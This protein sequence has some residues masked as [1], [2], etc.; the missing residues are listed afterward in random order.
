M[1]QPA[2]LRVNTLKS[3]T[4]YHKKCKELLSSHDSL[5][6]HAIGQATGMLIKLCEILQRKEPFK[7]KKLESVGFLDRKQYKKRKLKL[8]ALW[9]TP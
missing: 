2:I 5:E 9:E 3:L 8:V 7:L 1:Q 6:I 4:F